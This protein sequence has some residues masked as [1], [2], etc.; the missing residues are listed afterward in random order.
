M[1]PGT[2]AQR[3]PD[4]PAIVM[5]GS[6]D[7]VTF[8]Q[9]DER[10]NQLAHLFRNAGLVRGDHVALLMENHPRFLEVVWSA[11]RSGLYLTAINSHLTA[12][13][14]A[15]I[16]GDCEAQ[17]F[18]TSTNLSAVA[19]QIDWSRLPRVHVRLMVDGVVEGFERYEDATASRPTTPIDDE[20]SGATMLYSSGT[21]GRPK[22][23]LRPLADEKPWEGEARLAGLGAMYAFR[24]DM[25]YLSP[26]PMYHAAPL[27]F[28]ISAQRF[29]ATVVIL[30][31]FDPAAALQAIETHHVTHSQ[32]VPTM[33]VRLLRLGD[34]ERLGPDL[35]SHEVAIH[36]AAPCPVSV[37]QQM[38]EWW[39]PIIYEYYA[40]TEGNG[41]TA[42]TSEEWLAHPG[43]VG[44]PRAGNVHIVGE[45]GE[46]MRPL[47]EGGI[48]FSG[49]ATYEYHNDPAKTEEARL[50]GGLTTLGDV[51]YKDADGWLYLTDRK[52]Y[53]II[54]GGV[55]IYPRE[56]EDVF[57]QH[58]AVADVAVFG[59]PNDDLGE[60]VKAVVQ[61]LPDRA[62][63]PAMAEE[64]AA[65]VRSHLAGFK[66]P[67]TIDFTEELPR[68]PTGKLYKR[69]LRDPYWA[70]VS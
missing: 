23:V 17:A 53:M 69:V 70:G 60:E 66:C 3:H 33:F 45:D 1:Y 16:V 39:G 64:L 10:S 37:K 14:I 48:Y 61:L 41:S 55:N 25:V 22:G 12:D 19:G 38:I 6:H 56:I 13:E 44:R 52:A 49:G 18:V 30:E 54:S 50:P 58:P 24:E 43:S 11:L 59:I 32:W 27:A 42:I 51:G 9:L 40:G 46:E 63:T 8:R 47:E 35:S 28:S 36:A 29:G 4:R 67:R 7:V 34:A 31:R 26:A 2:I 5:A 65:F 68:L 57:I 20:S 15:Y 21:T 62:P